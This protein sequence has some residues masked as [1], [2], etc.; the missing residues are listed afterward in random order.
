MK[1]EQISI[2]GPYPNCSKCP[3]VL[4][5]FTDCVIVDVSRDEYPYKGTRVVPGITRLYWQC[6][7]NEH[8]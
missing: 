7:I 3:G 8:K 2:N 1:P 6:S 5:P 4:L